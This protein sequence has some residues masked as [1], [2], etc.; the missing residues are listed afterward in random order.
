[1]GMFDY[2]RSSY[3]LGENF[4]D[5]CLQ[6][7]DIEDGIGGTMSQYWI[8]PNG[9]LYYI[10]YTNTADF[11]E[12]KEGEDNYDEIRR[13]CNFRWVPNGNHGKISPCMLT[14]Y[15]EVYPDQWEGKWENWPRL[16]L[17]FFYGKLIGYG[18]TTGEP[19]KIKQR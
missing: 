4:T 10:D 5:T 2:I 7:K 19:W 18:D 1:M 3:D 14:K 9:V 16:K 17:H 8:S 6:T 11:V 13:W 12:I 15:I